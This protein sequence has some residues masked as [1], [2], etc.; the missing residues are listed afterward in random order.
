MRRETNAPTLTMEQKVTAAYLYI[1]KGVAQQDIAAAMNVN[2]GRISEA[3]T[4]VSR[5]LVTKD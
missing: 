3:V 2:H 1:V 5:A 4:K